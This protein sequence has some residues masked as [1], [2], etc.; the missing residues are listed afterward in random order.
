MLAINC[1]QSIQKPG[2]RK[3]YCSLRASGLAYALQKTQSPLEL[4][5]TWVWMNMQGGLKLKVFDND[6]AKI[7]VV[8]SDTSTHK[9][10]TKED[11]IEL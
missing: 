6:N 1:H 7:V 9:T 3:S 10:K 11:V 8:N 5:S 2:D 4:F